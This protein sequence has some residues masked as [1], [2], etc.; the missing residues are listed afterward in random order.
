LTIKNFYDGNFV[1]TGKKWRLSR[2]DANSGMDGT[3]GMNDRHDMGDQQVLDDDDVQ[4]QGASNKQCHKPS[5][6][7]ISI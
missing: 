7:T 2:Q 4:V 5:K 3:L 1:F 6:L